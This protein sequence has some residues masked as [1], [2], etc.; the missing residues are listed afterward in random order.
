MKFGVVILGAGASRRMGRP[1]LLLPWNGTT[2]IGHLIAQW[3]KLRATQ[4]VVVLSGD[5]QSLITELNRLEFPMENRIVNP[6]PEQGMVSSIQCAANWNGWEKSLT[7]IVIT[8]GDQP[9]LTQAT[10]LSL[11]EFSG[12]Q[13]DKICQPSFAG[14]P[15]H[16]VILPRTQFEK[17]SGGEFETLAHFLKAHR[18]DIELIEIDDPGLNLDLDT[19]ADFEKALPLS[20]G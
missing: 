10:L 6:Q 7:Q 15:K 9:H 3:K 2:L 19:P 8:L 13:V 16:P 12:D 4:I 20:G 18:Q 5:N 11:M 14:R 1:K 17:L